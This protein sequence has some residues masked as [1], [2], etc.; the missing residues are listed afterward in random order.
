MWGD[1]GA[2]AV[3]YAFCDARVELV[4][5]RRLIV[6]AGIHGDYGRCFLKMWY[7]FATGSVLEVEWVSESIGLIGVGDMLFTWDSI[8]CVSCRLWSSDCSMVSVSVA[9]N[10]L[11]DV[12]GNVIAL[13]PLHRVRCQPRL[14]VLVHRCLP[15]RKAK[16]CLIIMMRQEMLLCDHIRRVPQVFCRALTGESLGNL[17]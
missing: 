1:G 6:G 8:E 7:A 15:C 9:R 10:L 2:Y 13:R 17:Q 12:L 4:V 3:G 14:R 5:I 16:H 11:Y